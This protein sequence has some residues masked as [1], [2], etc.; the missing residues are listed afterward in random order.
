[1]AKLICGVG[2]K[3]TEYIHYKFIILNVKLL[4]RI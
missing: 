3:V 1:M 4:D 2:I